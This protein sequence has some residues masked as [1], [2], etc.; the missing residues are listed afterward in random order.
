M[1][2]PFSLKQGGTGIA[3]RNP[4]YL[5]QKNGERTFWGF[6][7]VIIRVP[8]IFADSIKSLTDFSYEYKLS[9]SIAPWDETY[10]EV[11]GSGVEMIDPVTYTFELGDSQWMLEVM[12]ENGWNSNEKLY[13]LWGYGLLIVLLLTGFAFAIILLRRTQESENTVSELNKKL[14]KALIAAETA[15]RAKSTFL[16][17]MSHDIRTPLNGI[18]GLLKINMAHGDDEDLVCVNN[19]K[20]E[21]TANHLLSLINDVLQMSKLEDGREE[22]SSELVCLPDV[23]YDMKAIIDGSALDKG[24]SVDFSEDSIWV[25]PYVITNPLYLRQIFLNIYGN[26]IKF[27]NF[28]GKISTK[29]ECIEEK[30]NVITYR[31]IISDTGIGMSK[32]FLKHIFE[33]FA[34]ERAD[35]RSNYHGTGL[36]MAIVKKMIDKMGGTVSVTSEVGKGSTFVVELPFEM[37]AAPEKS[38]KEEADKENSIHGLNLML[39]EDNEL[40]AEIAEILLEDEGAIITMVTDGQQAVELFNNNPEGTF[41]AILMDIM[42]PVMDGLTATKAIRALNRPDA[43]TIPIIAMTA[44]AFAE[45]VQR[46]LDAGMNAH[47]AKP[48]DIEKVKKTICEHIIGLF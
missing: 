41:D 20:M 23:F 9:K 26:G 29:Q 16:L 32:E 1:Q 35:A 40:N 8:D 2:G 31:W 15:N 44:N 42:M 27:T 7:I 19:Q 46:C 12:P 17:N 47:L 3:I 24:I 38:K 28:G 18:M 5:E 25:H 39:V 30:D 11:Y 48:L 34:Q 13:R 22:L 21:K 37:G 45:D 33:P 4:V 14:H 10:E 43:G 6:T 36:G